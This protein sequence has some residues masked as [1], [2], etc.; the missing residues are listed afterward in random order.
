MNRTM[1]EKENDD[2]KRQ[3]IKRKMRKTE[4]MKRKK[5]EIE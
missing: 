4:R 5:W 1:T 2:E 3:R